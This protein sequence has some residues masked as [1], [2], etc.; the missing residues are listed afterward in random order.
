MVTFCLKLEI[1]DLH[2]E[3]LEIVGKKL[4]IFIENLI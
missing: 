3:P 4:L 1:I 2:K